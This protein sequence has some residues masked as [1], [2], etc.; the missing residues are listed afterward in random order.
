[1]A[2]DTDS[3]PPT[4]E[5]LALRIGEVADLTGLGRTSVW[6]A[7]RRG[8]LRVCRLGPRATRIRMEDLQDFLARAT[9]PGELAPAPAPRRRGR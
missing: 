9:E 7:I 1:M 2:H 5:R 3:R 4:T 8:E 6:A